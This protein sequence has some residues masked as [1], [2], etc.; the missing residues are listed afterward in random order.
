MFCIL[1]NQ[2]DPKN[3]K[4]IYVVYT[5]S[6]VRT[7]TKKALLFGRALRNNFNSRG[8]FFTG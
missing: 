8:K 3:I 5:A 6:I 2:I 7:A 1:A 4:T